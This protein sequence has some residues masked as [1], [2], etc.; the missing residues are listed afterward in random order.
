MCVQ[1]YVCMSSLEEQ[2]NGDTCNATCLWVFNKDDGTSRKSLSSCNY[3]C[4][5]IHIVVG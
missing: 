4:E 2:M 5:Q 3:A 1:A